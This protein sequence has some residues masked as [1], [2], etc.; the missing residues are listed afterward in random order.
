[1]VDGSVYGDTAF[2]YDQDSRFAVR[3]IGGND[4]FAISRVPDD[5]GLLARHC[6]VNTP[7]GQVFLS[8]GDVRIHNGGGSESIADG[9]VRDWL[10]STLDT[11][12]AARSFLC[13]NPIKSEVWVCFPS[14]LSSSCNRA[15]VWNWK[16]NTW[17]DFAISGMTHAATG[18]VASGL[19]TG[20]IDN[21]MGIIDTDVSTIDEN[22][23]SPNQARLVLAFN[24]PKIGFAEAGSTDFGTAIEFMLERRGI[25]LDDPDL[26]KVF[27]ASRPQFKGTDGAVA[28]IYHGSSM[29]AD[30]SPVYSSAATYTHGTTN[31]VNQFANAGRYLA[32]KCVSTD[33]PLFFLR[34]IDFDLTQQG[35]F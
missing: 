5:E 12:Y 22:E 11:T 20:I 1:M 32:W 8:N 21:D 18:L 14:S 30:G 15:L 25:N 26:V 6:I 33:Y 28:S 16:D 24:T 17:G 9:R 34:S 31:W 23:F 35:R 2:I 13:V 27:G 29:T 4:V 10:R 7:K 19:D 3:Y